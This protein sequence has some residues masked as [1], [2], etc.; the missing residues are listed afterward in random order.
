LIVFLSKP[1]AISENQVFKKPNISVNF[2]V[3][4]S[5]QLKA[6]IPMDPIQYDFTYKATTEAGKEITGK[7][8]AISQEAAVAKL[9]EMKLSDITAEKDAIGREN[10]FGAYYQA[11]IQIKK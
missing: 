10:P 2:S 7:I 5:D 9:T 3:L 1:V 11:I 4:E 6:L 8:S